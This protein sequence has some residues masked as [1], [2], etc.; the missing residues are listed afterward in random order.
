[1]GEADRALPLVAE[2]IGLRVNFA[3]GLVYIVGSGW[4]RQDVSIPPDDAHASLRATFELW[5]EDDR[6]AHGVNQRACV[7]CEP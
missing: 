4:S 6:C 3:D 5:D 2:L 7:V 1:M